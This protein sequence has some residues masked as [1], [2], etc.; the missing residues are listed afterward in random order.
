MAAIDQATAE[1]TIFLCQCIEMNFRGVLIKPRCHL[2]LGFFDGHAIDVI[3]LFANRIIIP[4]EIRSSQN[5]VIGLAIN[6]RARIAQ[7]IRRN[8]TR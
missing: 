2:M 7:G 6:Q 8:S 5:I 4:A 1:A 3:N